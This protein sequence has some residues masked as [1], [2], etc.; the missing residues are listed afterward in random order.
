MSLPARPKYR[1]T[2][3]ET[4]PMEAKETLIAFQ[5]RDNAIP[6]N[7]ARSEAL[8]CQVEG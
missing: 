3:P 4:S 7:A 5:V 6:S 1:K 8:T 2:V